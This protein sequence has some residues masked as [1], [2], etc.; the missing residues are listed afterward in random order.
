MTGSI[1]QQDRIGKLTTPFGGDTLALMSL[2]ATEGLSELFEFRL[3]AASLQSNLDFNSALGDEKRDIIGS[4]TENIGKDETVNVGMAPEDISKGGGNFTLNS[5]KSISLHVGP[6]EMPL[7]H[8]VMDQQSI[9]L[10]VGTKDM[11]MSQIKMTMADITLS[12]GPEGVLAKTTLSMSGIQHAVLAGITN[13]N[14]S[15]ASISMM[16]P[17]ISELALASISLTG[18]AGVSAATNLQTPALVAG[19]AVIGGVPI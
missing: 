15:P 9:T 1:S 16:S 14:L 2:H 13:V 12:V 18:A 19:A 10:S 11:P 17:A 6:K 7:T 4:Q 3:K 5:F 8:I